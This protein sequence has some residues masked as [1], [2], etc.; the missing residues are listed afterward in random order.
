MR[1]GKRDNAVQTEYST[2]NNQR[3]TLIGFVV[4]F[5]LLVRADA[6]IVQNSLSPN[7][8]FAIEEDE[9]SFY[10]VRMADRHRCGAVIPEDEDLSNVSVEEI[11]WNRQ[12]KAVALK[13]Y[14][15]TKLGAVVVFERAS[16]GRFVERSFKYPDPLEFYARQ[17][18]KYRRVENY[19][20]NEEFWVG[21][22]EDDRTVRFLVGVDKEESDQGHIHFL[23]SLRVT[24]TRGRVV[25]DVTPMGV[26]DENGAKKI[27]LKWR[28]QHGTHL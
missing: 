27:V 2:M 11:R 9:H 22:W 16:N 4:L 14:Y 23:L 6:D 5:A 8:D 12:T 28:A 10:F 24:L 18:P 19:T 1:E 26:V 3:C 25:V 13:Y 15:G 20:G 17:S 7:R 21:R